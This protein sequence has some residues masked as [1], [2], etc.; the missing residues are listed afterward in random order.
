VLFPLAAPNPNSGSFNS[1]ARK[2]QPSS[3]KE[4]NRQTSEKADFSRL[5]GEREGNLKGG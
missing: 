2:Q 1:A 4:G 5:P 3:R